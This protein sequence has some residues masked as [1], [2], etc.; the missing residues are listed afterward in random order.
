MNEFREKVGEILYKVSQNPS[1]FES[2]PDYMLETVSKELFDIAKKELEANPEF[3]YT[4][5]RK[6]AEKA[7]KYV[8]CKAMDWLED[9]FIQYENI[10]DYNPME[11]FRKAM[12]EQE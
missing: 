5:T 7:R 1:H 2:D 11:D 12:E 3:L 8:I 6:A 9:L 10:T 4:V